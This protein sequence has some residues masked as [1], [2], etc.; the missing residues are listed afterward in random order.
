MSSSE[1]FQKINNLLFVFL[2]AIVKRR[3][4]VKVELKLHYH[5]R[6]FTFLYVQLSKNI[7]KCFFLK[8]FF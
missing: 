2:L 3:A 8:K 6:G 4:G 7:T 5:F 1:Q